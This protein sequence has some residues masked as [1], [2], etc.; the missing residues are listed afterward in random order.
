M[1][2]PRMGADIAGGEERARG[3]CRPSR[4]SR[5]DPRVPISQN[6][7]RLAHWQ[8]NVAKDKTLPLHIIPRSHSHSR[9]SSHVVTSRHFAVPTKGNLNAT[10]IMPAERAGVR[11]I[12]KTIFRC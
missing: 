9:Y 1:V 5:V 2:V 10:A 8:Q 7:T 12:R 11:F 3:M 6:V 4:G